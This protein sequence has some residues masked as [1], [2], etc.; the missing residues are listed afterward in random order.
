MTNSKSALIPPGALAASSTTRFSKALTVANR[1]G[2]HP[3]TIHR[4]AAAGLIQRYKI[5]D[6]VVLFEEDEVQRF[7]ESSQVNSMRK[8]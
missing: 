8:V 7:I 2:L 4:W 6:R 1:I 5:N 3:K